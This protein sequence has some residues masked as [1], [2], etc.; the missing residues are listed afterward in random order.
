MA[1]S[2]VTLLSLAVLL[3]IVKLG[4]STMCYQCNSQSQ[5]ECGDPFK[6]EKI[7]LVD[8]N[9]EADVLGYNNQYLRPL[10]AGF[11]YNIAG[12]TKYCHKIVTQTGTVL[13]VCLE[14]NPSAMNTTCQLL[15]KSQNIKHCSVCDKDNCNGAGSL[16][17]SLSL[18]VAALFASYLFLKH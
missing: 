12:A 11:S 9:N 15:A 5:T 6:K 1:R 14:D 2:A 7:R 8:C 18:A 10:L 4:S 3:A 17:A 13:R 16:S